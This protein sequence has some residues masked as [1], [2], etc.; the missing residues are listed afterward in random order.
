MRIPLTHYGLPQVIIVPAVIVVT[1]AI[2]FFAACRFLQPA[3]S[4]PV[5]KGLIWLPELILLI[6]LVWVFSFFRD[7][8][9]AVPQDPSLLLSPADGTIAAVETLD[10]YDGFDGPVWRCEIFLSIFN[11]HINRVPCPVKIGQIT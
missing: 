10:S 5:S 6:V 2:Y 4:C 3:C 9:R 7:P 11:V 1:M 8:Q